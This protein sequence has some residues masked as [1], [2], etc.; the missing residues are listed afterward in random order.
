MPF[1]FSQLAPLLW[2]VGGMV[3]VFVCIAIFSDNAS[4]GSIKSRQ[5]G[6]GQ[7]GTARWATKKEMGNTY[8]HLPFLPEQWRK[9]VKCPEKQG[10]VV[11]SVVSGPP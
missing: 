4:L 5:V 6:D 8:L 10:L 9:G 7:H 2:T 11:G 1:D 3:A